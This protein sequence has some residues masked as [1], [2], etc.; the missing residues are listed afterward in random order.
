M[1]RRLGQNSSFLFDS[2]PQSMENNHCNNDVDHL[3]SIAFSLRSNAIVVTSTVLYLPVC[4]DWQRRMCSVLGLMVVKGNRD[5]NEKTLD[6]G[7]DQAP[8]IQGR[9]NS[10]GN[11]FFRAVA[12]EVSG[13]QRIMYNS[14][15]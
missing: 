13:S 5:H 7:V 14:E 3:R 8:N 2:K 11:S 1:E 6:I 12:Q 4:R 10:D 15:Y 9:I